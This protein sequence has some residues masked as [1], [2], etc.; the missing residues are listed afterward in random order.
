MVGTIDC[1]TIKKNSVGKL[2]GFDQQI[3]TTVSDLQVFKKSVP[4]VFKFIDF[5][6][7]IYAS[8]IK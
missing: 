8:F 6:S 7:Y 2:L 1:G 4:Q 5:Y 3:N